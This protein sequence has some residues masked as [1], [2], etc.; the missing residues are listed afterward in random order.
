MGSRGVGCSGDG[1]R[2]TG[3]VLL[4]YVCESRGRPRT[5]VRASRCQRGR[6]GRAGRTQPGGV[7]LAPVA[8][9]VVDVLLRG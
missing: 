3:V 7:G 4:W 8:H 2:T 5:V 9:E 6:T 1:L